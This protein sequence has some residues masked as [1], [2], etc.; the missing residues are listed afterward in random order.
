[1]AAHAD[2]V[3]RCVF[4]LIFML[5]LDAVWI[6]GNRT[7]YT[8]AVR[9]VQLQ[10]LKVNVVA[11]VLSYAFIY[12]AMLLIAMPAITRPN[13]GNKQSMT[14]LETLKRSAIYAGGLGLVIY[15]V[16]NMTTKALLHRYPWKVGIA[17]TLWGTVMFTTVCFL[18]LVV[19][20]ACIVAR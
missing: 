18:T 11:T 10:P 14:A 3:L 5:A 6:T 8:N 7:M 1:M 9:D 19:V 13:H 4:A 20:K 15:G 17:D 12:G 2:I 16:Y